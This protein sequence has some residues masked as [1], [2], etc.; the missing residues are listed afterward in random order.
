[1][2][3]IAKLTLKMLSHKWASLTSPLSSGMATKI[4]YLYLRLITLE[5]KSVSIAF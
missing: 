4:S 3:D 2:E 1:M 5:V